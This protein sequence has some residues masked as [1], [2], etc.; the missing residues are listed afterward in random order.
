[1]N[2]MFQAARDSVR[3]MFMRVG[4]S[5]PRVIFAFLVFLAG[6]LIARSARWAIVKA[7]KMVSFDDL[8]EKIHI[9]DFLR[10][11]EVKVNLSELVGIFVY[12][13]IMLAFLLASLDLLGMTVAAELLER[14][15]AYVPQVIAGILVLILGLFSATLVSGVVQTAAANAGVG[16]AKALGQIARM[17]VVIFAS[18]VALEKFLSSMIIQTTF[19]TVVMAFAFGAALAFGLG[20]KDLAG[21]AVQDFVNRLNG[22]R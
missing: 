11:G 18:A 8:A 10:R 12:W 7:L 5:L 9:N 4:D 20:C 21:K 19:N 17:V 16:Q 15:L 2:L 1:M 14:I 3:A 22:G 6:W 13:L